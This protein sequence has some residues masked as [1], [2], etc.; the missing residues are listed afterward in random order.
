MQSSL[1]MLLAGYLLNM[2][3]SA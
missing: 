3:L 2:N 1:F